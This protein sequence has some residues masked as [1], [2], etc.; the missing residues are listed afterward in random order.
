MAENF[1]KIIDLFNS[2][3]ESRGEIRLN[4]HEGAMLYRFALQIKEGNIL[5]IGRA[6]GGSTVL[7]TVAT[8]NTKTRI[9]SIDLKDIMRTKH[10]FKDYTEKGR[11]DIRIDNSWEMKNIPISM[12][13]VDGDHSYDGIKKDFVHHW[14]YLDGPCLAH[15][16]TCP[17]CP[18]VTKFI[19]EWV[20]KGYAEILEQQQTMVALKKI[21]N[22]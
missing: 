12:L 7:L 6:Y 11:V 14:N 17:R 2:T 3:K 8:H 21:K 4:L 15:D 22:Y 20:E 16:Y 1:L 9:V 19:N 13:W 18:G 5:E 10:F